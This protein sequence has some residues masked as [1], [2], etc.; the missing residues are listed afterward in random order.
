MHLGEDVEAAMGVSEREYTGRDLA[1]L[2]VNCNRAL[3]YCCQPRGATRSCLRYELGY[4]Q[5]QSSIKL[6][7]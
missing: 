6:M 7:M 3:A 4:L 2:K 1:F 5:V